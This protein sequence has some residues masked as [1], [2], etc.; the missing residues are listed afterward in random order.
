MLKNQKH[1]FSLPDHITYLNGSYMS[2]Q[3][4]TVEQI[5]IHNLKIKSQP[6]LITTA[7]FFSEKKVLR[8]R[9][10]QLINAED[11]NSIA[12]IPSVSFG[13][14]TV[15]KNIPFS[16]GD[17]IVVLEE[18]FPSNFY[19][20]KEL[21]MT[22]GVVVKTI[23]AP[24]I[25]QDRG[26]RWNE[27]V[28]EAITTKTKCIAIPHVHWADGTKFDLKTIRNRANDVDAYLIIDGT[29]SIGAM[30]FSLKEIMPDA[31]VCAGYKWLMGAYG[32][33]LAYFGDKFDH[34]TPVDNNWM[35]H[36]GAENF[37]NLVN[38]NH[39]FKS[40]ALRY[41]IGESSNFILVPMLAEGIKQLLT[42]TPFSIQEYC[43]SITEGPL[44]QLKQHG[45]FVEEKDHCVHHLFGIYLSEEKSLERIKQELSAM[46]IIV[47]YRGNAIRVSP[48]VYN[49]EEELEK[50]VSCFL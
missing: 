42:W 6:F 10:A 50:L 12:I 7:D 41:D 37:S 27:R 35:N 1:L 45:Y 36:Q 44:Q 25:S 18:Q 20:W 5:G 30:P 46:G 8:E 49:T 31:L 23:A 2:P 28:L 39:N 14:A 17:E 13:I 48:N 29:Q 47:S 33:G 11:P 32:L 16:A 38:Y 15:L 24:E 19:A 21:E 4:K 22:E 3:L 26:K 34:G 40:K 43:K 9:F